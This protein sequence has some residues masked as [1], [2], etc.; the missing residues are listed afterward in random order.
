MSTEVGAPAATRP[1]ERGFWA[2]RSGIVLAGLVALLGIYLT[3]GVITMDVPE[4]ARSPGPR[5]FPIILA[6]CCYVLAALLALQF[7]RHPEPAGDGEAWDEYGGPPPRTFSDWKALGVAL[8]GFLVFALLM[9]PAGWIISAAVL[10]WAVSWSM[11]S[12]RPLFDAALSLVFSCAIQ[13][14]FSMGLGLHLPSGILEG[15]F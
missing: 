9:E 3:V 11:G 4:G 14:A 6:V 10:F 7:I 5:F 1:G 12:R 13:V 8:V 15:L 2:G